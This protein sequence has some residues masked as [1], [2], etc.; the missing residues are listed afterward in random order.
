M[1]DSDGVVLL[2]ETSCCQSVLEEWGGAEASR[3]DRQVTICRVGRNGKF[4]FAGVYIDCLRT[5]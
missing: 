4:G 3:V 5:D 1:P 2:D